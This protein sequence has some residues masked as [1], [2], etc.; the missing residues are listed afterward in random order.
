MEAAGHLSFLLEE[1]ISS[2]PKQQLTVQEDSLS[3]HEWGDVAAKL[4]DSPEEKRQLKSE[5]RSQTA[6]PPT[7]TVCSSAFPSHKV[8]SR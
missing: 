2:L 4:Q 7:S 1:F 5:T 3:Q 8:I 6:A